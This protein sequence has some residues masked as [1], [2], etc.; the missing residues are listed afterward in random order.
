MRCQNNLFT[1]NPSPLKV[2]HNKSRLSYLLNLYRLTVDEFLV[3]I[4]EGLK[5]PITRE[6]IFS[7]EIKISHLKRIDKIFEKG[8]HYYLDPKSPT[9]SKA[10]SIF[11]RKDKFSTELNIGAKKI[12]NKFEDLKIS[13]SAISKLAGLKIERKLPVISIH[14]PPEKVA[15]NIREVLYPKV[16]SRNLRDFLKSLIASL[17]GYNILVFEFV[18]TWNK[19]EKANI[20]GLFL[21]PNVI[22]L[23]RQQE[24][25]RREIFTLAHELG[26]YLLNEE[27][28]EKVDYVISSRSN[29]S[30][31][32]NWC[33]EFAF[34]FLAGDYAKNINELEPASLAND[35]HFKLIERIS[36]DTHLS[37]LALYTK[38][39]YNRKIS[40]FN[41][42]KIKTNFE[43]EYRKKKEAEARKKE[44]EKAKGTKQ[45]GGPPQAINSP[46]LISTIQKAFYEGV[47]N[48]YEVCKRLNINPEQLEKMVQ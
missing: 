26:H 12:V 1:S 5:N 27:E 25:F 11:F 6:D 17:A 22:V 44:L 8:L 19:K 43:E 33:N 38:L 48:E 39:L 41:Y 46:L 47:L 2:E 36:K 3:M 31:I 7:D 4:S 40:Q 35:Y 9:P 18:E 16:F 20:D 28:I 23:K 42:N 10:A 24:S 30:K 45:R 37:R 34:Y 13:L 14:N 29:L 21:S 32:E 15:S